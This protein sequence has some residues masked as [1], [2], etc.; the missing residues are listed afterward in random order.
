MYSLYPFLSFFLTDICLFAVNSTGD[1]LTP[2]AKYD[3]K[4]KDYAPWV[5]RGLREKFGIDPAD[6]LVSELLRIIFV[7]GCIYS[8]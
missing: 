5:F 7:T 3:F 6:Y 1:E 4:F 8:F 2:G